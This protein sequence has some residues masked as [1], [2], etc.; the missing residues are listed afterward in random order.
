VEN[1]TPADNEFVH[2]ADADWCTAEV[3]RRLPP[4]RTPPSILDLGCG[5][6]GQTILLASHFRCSVD[7]VD[8]RSQLL[9]EMMEAACAAGV[10]Q[11]V[12]PRRESFDQL[13]AGPQSYDLVWCAHA[14]HVLGFR[15][16][17]ALWGPLLH[18]RGVMVIGEPTWMVGDAPEELAEYCARAYPEMTDQAGNMRIAEANGLSVEDV[19]IPS[20]STRWQQYYG[21][22]S[23][24]LANLRARPRGTRPPA[25]SVTRAQLQIDMFSRWGD[26]YRRLFYLLRP[27]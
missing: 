2:G 18:P 5:R 10:G 11:W 21:P 17:L 4:L 20:R 25:K 9:D 7:A 13:A 22:L 8:L 3:L 14:A 16:S 6:G 19:V 12:R 26:Y 27:A 24:R 15:R 1:S 23:H